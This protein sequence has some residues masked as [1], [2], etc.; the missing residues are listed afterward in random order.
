MRYP[1]LLLAIILLVPSVSFSQQI[2]KWKDDKGQWHFSHTPPAGAKT[3]IVG[4]D[5]P[6]PPGTVEP[7][8]KE[9]KSSQGG[10]I[11]EDAGLSFNG[12]RLE[13]EGRVK[14][15]GETL[16]RNVQV[17]PEFGMRGESSLDP[18]APRQ[19]R[20]TFDQGKQAYSRFE[21]RRETVRRSL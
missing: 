9:L 3:E 12:E 11:I 17:G 7:P 1:D 15:A 18:T 2:Y 19:N 14:N 4:E 5:K 16:E 8:R 6:R 10:L 13:I 21:W 20:K